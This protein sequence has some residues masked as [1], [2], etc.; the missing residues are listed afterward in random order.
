M[1]RKVAE[2][3]DQREDESIDF[4][5]TEALQNTK[6]IAK[7]LVAFAN[8]NGGEL[9]FGIT[10]DRE[11][12][13]SEIDEDRETSRI[14]KVAREKCSPPIDISHEFYPSQ[15]DGSNCGDILAIQIDKNSHLPSAVTN[16]TAR[17]FYI[18]T[19]NESRP[20]EDPE[21][22]HWL[23]ENTSDPYISQKA[24]LFISATEDLSIDLIEPFPAAYQRFEEYFDRLTDDDVEFLLEEKYRLERFVGEILPFAFLSHIGTTIGPDFWIGYSDEEYSHQTI[25]K[26]LLADGEYDE[27]LFD[28]IDYS[29]ESV[30]DEHGNGQEVPDSIISQLSISPLEILVEAEGQ[31]SIVIPD[32]TDLQIEHLNE[33]ISR[34]VLKK[35]GCFE[36]WVDSYPNTGSYTQGLPDLH[37]LSQTLSNSGN[38]ISI[39]GTLW[40][41]CN[42]DF[43][44]TE[45]SNITQHE[46]FG[47]GLAKAIEREWEY[48]HH[49][50]GNLGSLTRIE[51]K[52]DN[53]DS[54]IDRLYEK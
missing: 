13:G 52:I 31:R 30:F 22:L 38:M 2:Y 10:D 18:R 8:R 32:G 15:D 6:S 9:I 36:F 16:G 41:E 40:I 21:E 28:K 51:S 53:L 1:D 14:S 26:S 23:F 19:A 27:I 43:P 24:D 33:N 47:Q 3:L 5:R 50:D 35:Q 12:Q 29:P 39:S 7:Q 44:E 37:P 45:N 11:I 48:K 25:M 20:I 49:I 54:K 17:T 34:L 42:F 4:K 46:A